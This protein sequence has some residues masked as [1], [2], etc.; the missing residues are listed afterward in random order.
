[1]ASVLN[2][3]ASGLEAATRR[4]SN[5]ANNIANSTT[6]RP[7]SRGSSTRPDDVFAPQRT[8]QTSVPGGGVRVEVNPV[9]PSTVTGPDISSP[10]GL[11]SFP[12]VNLLSEYFV[13]KQAIVSYKA[14]ASVIRTQQN[15]DKA[16]LDIET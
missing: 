8:V 5:S 6:S 12:N 9:D 1:M 16:L 7:A 13:Q 15:L 4:L 10:T 14:N 11:S 3:A 2:I